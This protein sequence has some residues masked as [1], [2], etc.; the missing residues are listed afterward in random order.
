MGL[1]T[2]GALLPVLIRSCILHTM[3]PTHEHVG[4]SDFSSILLAAMSNE[5]FIE[6]YPNVA[7]F[8]VQTVPRT[9]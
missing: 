2:T 5:M 6:C 3:T 8:A 1:E 4:S 9:L 7:H